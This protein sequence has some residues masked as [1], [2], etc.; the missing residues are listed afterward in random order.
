M[1][2]RFSADPVVFATKYFVSLTI[3]NYPAMRTDSKGTPFSIVG[4]PIAVAR[5]TTKGVEWIEKGN[6]PQK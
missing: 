2:S 6:C 5:L 3:D 4:G 1:G